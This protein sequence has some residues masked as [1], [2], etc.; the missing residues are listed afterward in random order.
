M[1]IES[2]LGFIPRGLPRNIPAERELDPGSPARTERQPDMN[3][4]LAWY[5]RAGSRDD[6]NGDTSLLAARRFIF[7]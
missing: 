1:V 7:S 5:V 6:R 2:P 4:I 3:V